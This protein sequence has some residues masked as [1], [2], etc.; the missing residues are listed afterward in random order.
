MT[1]L[2]PM[3]DAMPWERPAAPPRLRAWHVYLLF[4]CWTVF[5]LYVYSHF[6]TLGDSHTYLSGAYDDDEHAARTLVITYLAEGAFAL[7]RVEFLAHLAFSLFAAT[8]VAYLVRQA[9]PHGRFRWPLLAILLT[10]NFGV[11]SSVIGRESLFVALLGW[12]LGAVIGY[13]RTPG[14]RRL[15]LAILCIA[16]MTFIRSPYGIG[17]GLFFL[18]VLAYRSGPRM[19][20]SIG[21]QTLLF[22]TV[23]G[24]VLVAAWPYLDDYIANEVL[25]KAKGYFTVSSETTR[26]WIQLNST[27]TLFSSLWWTLPLALVG[28]TPGEVAARPMMLPFLVSGAVVFGCLLY[29]VGVAFRAPPGRERKILLLGWLPAVALILV[30]YVPFGVYNSGSAIRYASCFLLFLVFPSLLLSSVDADAAAHAAVPRADVPELLRRS[31][32]HA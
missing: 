12:F 21:L 5:S 19:N 24:M 18:M 26:T 27:Q 29:S 3:Q 30:A 1:R 17:M 11:W 16:G 31:L 13:Y 2:D 20:L 14:L 8:G 32:G 9:R 25:P 7:L 6:S 10:P 4:F 28:P 15:T 22:A 23:C